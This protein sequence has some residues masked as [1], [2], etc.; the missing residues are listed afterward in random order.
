MAR[1]PWRYSPR[2][3]S[4]GPPRGFGFINV[5]HTAAFGAVDLWAAPAS[6]GELT[7]IA[8]GLTN[9]NNLSL[10]LPVGQYR[11]VVVPAGAGPESAALSATLPVWD[12][13]QYNV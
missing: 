9:P 12:R 1:R 5:R 8:S 4:R 2:P 13:Q 7:K 3:R 10:M 11:V 6:G